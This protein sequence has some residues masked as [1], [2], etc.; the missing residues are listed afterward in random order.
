MEQLTHITRGLIGIAAFIGI[1]VIFSENRRAIP[2]KL[3]AMGLLLQIACGVLVLKVDFVRSMV[4]AVG[5]AFVAILDFNKAGTQFLFGSL[6]TDTKS[7]GYLFA[8]NVLPTIVFFSALTSLLF[9]LGLLQ[10][11]VY[12]FAWLMSKTMKLSGAESL[13]ASANI[14]LGQTEAPLLIKPYLPTMTRSELLA[15]MIGGMANIA[16]AVL[17]AYIG[18]LGGED[19]VQRLAFAKHLI[20][21]SIMSAPASLYIA[22]IMLPQTEPVDETIIVPKEKIGANALEAVA[23]GTTDGVKLAVNVGAMLLVFTALIAMANAMLSHG[24]GSWS[25]LNDWIAAT[26]AGRYTEFS[27]QYICGIVFAPLG[28][29]MGIDYGSLTTAGQVIGE[30]TILNEFYAYGTLG[31]L[32]ASGQIP[33]QRAQIILTYALCGFAN[34]ASIGIQV[35]GIG[36]LAPNQRGALAKLGVKSLIGGSLCC[37]LGASIAGALL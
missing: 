20:T 3:V 15:V 11:I 37:F 8:F 29:L 13:S 23:N 34:V 12:V 17:V 31:N 6:V 28:W 4:D 25:G 32:I 10:K 19:P 24:I 35:G 33:D 7:F 21:A 22:K 1:A 36:T 27:L 16:G 14:F 18:M 5:N 26:T 2:W 9:Y 30:K